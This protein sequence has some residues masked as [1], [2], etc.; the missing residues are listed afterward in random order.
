L[1]DRTVNSIKKIK[2]LDSEEWDTIKIFINQIDDDIKHIVSDNQK[3][4]DYYESSSFTKLKETCEVLMTTQRD[5]NEYITEKE[6][7]DFCSNCNELCSRHCVIWRKAEI[8]YN[9]E[10]KLQKEGR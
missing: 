2:T 7:K 8:R 3:I 9:E 4:L 6:V 1:F 10:E 5:F